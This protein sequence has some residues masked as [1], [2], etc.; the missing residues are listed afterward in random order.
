M[1]SLSLQSKPG[2]TSLTYT[3]SL[4]G[5]QISSRFQLASQ[6]SEE[7][8]NSLQANIYNRK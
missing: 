1:E 4:P 7:F 8:F 2:E 6:V 5:A 3:Y